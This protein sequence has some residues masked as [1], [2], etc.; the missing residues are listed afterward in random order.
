MMRQRECSEE[1]PP[2]P[3]RMARKSPPKLLIMN[4]DLH[5]DCRDFEAVPPQL[6]CYIPRNQLELVRRDKK[7]DGQLCITDSIC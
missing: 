4:T 7:V 1:Y 5:V 3:A 6:N 2:S